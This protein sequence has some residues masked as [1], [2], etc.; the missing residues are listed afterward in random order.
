MG[1][2]AMQHVGVERKPAEEYFKI[3]EAV[4]EKVPDFAE[5]YAIIPA[6]SE[7]ESFGDLDC[8][9]VVSPNVADLKATLKTLFQPSDIKKNG[10]V[11]SFDFQKLQIDVICTSQ[12]YF[13]SS[14]HYY[15]YNDV[16]N[17]VGRTAHK[18]GLKYGH[19]G[20]SLPVRIN[21]THEIGTVELSTDPREMLEFMGYDYDRFQK[22]FKN[23]EEIFSYVTTSPYFDK[24]A[25]Q[26]ENLNHINRV[27]NRKRPTFTNFVQWL[28]RPE[29]TN[30]PSYTYEEDKTPYIQR[31]LDHFEHNNSKGQLENILAAHKKREDARSK[32]SGKIV[33]ELTGLQGKELGAFI[34]NFSKQWKTPKD[35]ETWAISTP[36]AQIK[37]AIVDFQARNPTMEI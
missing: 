27:R 19:K 22:G 7:K 32:F 34:V 10:D 9:V 15:S 31:A 4:L 29:N 14:L 8:L 35:L 16:S 28:Q 13:E 11:W 33:S 2:N 18:M 26:E 23:L 1:G 20:L 24:T 12:K 6:Y 17:L 36:E 3:A 25:F 37:K 21:N 30:L 5:R